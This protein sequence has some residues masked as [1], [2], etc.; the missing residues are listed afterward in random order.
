MRDYKMRAPKRKGLCNVAAIGA[1][2]TVASAVITS[3]AAGGA[4]G[5]A[6][7]GQLEANGASIGETRREFDISQ[8]KY[9]AAQKVLQPWIATGQQGMTGQQDL[10]GLNGAPQ[11]Q[12]A[13]DELQK[14]P[15][16]TSTQKLGENRILANASATGGLRGG[17]VQGALSQF[18]GTLL[19][20]II[21]QQY[22]NYAGLSSNGLAA[23]GANGNLA[24]G[25]A[26][27]AQNVG[28][29]IA[30]VLQ[31]NGQ[32]QAGGI[33][34]QANAGAG[35]ASSLANGAGVI[36]GKFLGPTPATPASTV[37]AGNGFGGFSNAEL[38][39]G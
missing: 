20:Q 36:A 3:S 8:A 28:S 13:I 21:Q 29:S 2:A 5:A 17:N 19:S 34:G 38:F 39:A 16:F 15:Q 6:A 26:G 30:G 32:V 25:A 33:L 7:G 22:A 35:L 11:Q 37:A 12:F 10:L 1:A 27:N 9:D 18:N 23:A 31:Q 14:G 24:A 4:A